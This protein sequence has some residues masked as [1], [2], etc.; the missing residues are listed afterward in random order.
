MVVMGFAIVIMGFAVVD[1]GLAIVRS[2]NDYRWFTSG[3]GIWSISGFERT[4]ES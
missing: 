2:S 1:M 3:F 4:E